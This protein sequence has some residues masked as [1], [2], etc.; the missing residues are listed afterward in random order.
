MN[1]IIRVFIILFLFY[2]SVS[3]G[4]V[5]LTKKEVLKR[6]FPNADEIIKERFW[7]DDE[8]RTKIGKLSNQKVED[9]RL[10]FYAGKKAEKI[11]GY[12]IID[13]FIGKTLPITYMV[14]LN[15]DGTVRDVAIMIY[16][17]S[18]GM[19]V[20]YK[21]FLKQF[22]GKKAVSA[23]NDINAVTGATISVRSITKGVRKAVSAY[24][25]LFLGDN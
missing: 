17:E 6:A 19:E 23:F 13:H 2:P 9:K 7:L 11:I 16:R 24:Q 20:R 21:F 1:H 5:Y 10:V 12:M 18:R 25:V 14:V 15:I 3:A 4:E 8:Q 22:F